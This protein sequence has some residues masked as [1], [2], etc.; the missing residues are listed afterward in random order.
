M[1]LT[2]VNQSDLSICILKENHKHVFQK[3]LKENIFIPLAI[4]ICPCPGPKVKFDQFDQR[5]NTKHNGI[6]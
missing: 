2:T 6:A 5:E 3:D 4:L 1:F